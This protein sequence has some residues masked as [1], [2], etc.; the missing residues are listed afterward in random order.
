MSMRDGMKIKLAK[1][2]GGLVSG[3]PEGC[4]SPKYAMEIKRDGVR[5]TIQFTSKGTI[6]QGRSKHGKL[7]GVAHA[8]T[9]CFVDRSEHVPHVQRLVFPELRG[10]LLDT[11][12]VW[13]EDSALAMCL[14]ARGHQKIYVF[15]ILFHNGVDVRNQPWHKRRKLV[16]KIVRIVDKEFMVANPIFA[17]TKAQHDKI[18][19]KGFE[20]TILK[21]RKGV[22]D[23]S[24]RTRT[25]WWKAKGE[26]TVDAFII[27]V[28][29]AKSGGSPKRGIKPKPI[30]RAATMTVGMYDAQGNVVEVGKCRFTPEHRDTLAGTIWKAWPG[31]KGLVVE[32]SAS[33]FN[34]KRYRFC[35]LKRIRYDK[36]KEECILPKKVAKVKVKS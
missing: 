7:K 4:W 18:M 30:A 22:Y 2:R 15:D 6:L 35:Q 8:N 19:K 36:L 24:S 10:T 33:G 20:G 5:Q 25:G 29:Q 21:S 9:Q 13:G 3:V 32:M 31:H 23:A 34:K 27:S 14:E 16:E 26:D 12:V 17:A 28:Q 11:E 1:P